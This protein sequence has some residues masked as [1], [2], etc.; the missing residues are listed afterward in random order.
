MRRL[1]RIAFRFHD[2]VGRARIPE[3]SGGRYTECM[4]ALEI[5]FQDGVS[6]PETLFV[7]RPVAL[8]GASD[9]AHVV[10]EDMRGLEYM[11]QISREV[12]RKFRCRPVPLASGAVLP[13]ILESV[14][15]GSSTLDLGVVRLT[16][17]SLDSDLLMRENEPPDR[18]GARI[19]RVALATPS[20]RFPAM[21][22][23]GDPL[24][25]CSFVADQPLYVGR[26]KFCTL[27]IDAAEVSAKHARVGFEGGRFWV[28]DLG[29]T[30]GVFVNSAQIAG[31]TFFQP[32]AEISLGHTI[33]LVGVISEEGL[34]EFAKDTV[35]P[36]AQIEVERV[37]A[38]K[39]YPVLVSVSEVVRPARLPLVAGA[40]L[41]IGRDPAS[42]MWLGAPHVS[43]RHCEIVTS[44]SGDVKV[45][46]HSTNGTVCNGD[47]L[48]RGEVLEID[49]KPHVLD[50][51]GGITVALCFNET[52]ERSFVSSQGS[53]S[54]F[55]GARGNAS[56]SKPSRGTGT[57]LLGNG[58]GEHEDSRDDVGAIS[59]RPPSALERVSYGLKRLFGGGGS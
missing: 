40:T 53:P 41:K 22:V 38:D 20:P 30:H 35:K 58:D 29:S 26:S 27:R 36:A 1:D 47:V 21:L 15:D 33:K 7:R 5:S 54:V 24:V 11:L 16:I 14:Y 13:P 9:Q 55:S 39:R 44:P 48:H 51:G 28:E 34:G 57:D 23:K 18:A 59:R 31:R 8:V 19:M 25:M 37:A 50:F 3:W 45:V 49:E 17:T 6:Q 10:I 56:L 43:R 2:G 42:D 32:G 52:Q 12:G 4:F 46:D